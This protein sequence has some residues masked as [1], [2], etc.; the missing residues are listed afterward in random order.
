M[1]INRVLKLSDLSPAL[2]IEL[3]EATVV[4]ANN[5]A[6][7]FYTTNDQ[8]HWELS[9]DFP[10]V[11]PPWPNIWLE[12][13]EPKFINS[14]VHGFYQNPNYHLLSQTG[15]Y[16]KFQQ[17]DNNPSI[18]NIMPKQSI[19]EQ[20]ILLLGNHLMEDYKK[21]GIEITQDIAVKLNEYLNEAKKHIGPDDIEFFNRN[22]K[23]KLQ[24]SI[25]SMGDN[26]AKWI[27]SA[28]LFVESRHGEI[29]YGRVLVQGFIDKNGKFMGSS[30]LEHNKGITV[31]CN[32]NLPPNER[33]A[34]SKNA[35]V[36][37]HVPF[38]TL[39]FIHCKNVKLQEHNLS[40]K[41]SEKFQ[42][43]RKKKTPVYKYY[44]L[45]IDP[46]KSVLKSEGGS[47]QTGLRRALH[48]CRGHFA[49]YTGEAPLFGKVTG[50]FWKSM[51]L[52][53]DA[54][55]GKIDKDYRVKLTS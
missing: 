30:H 29:S 27:M 47:E 34:I 21:R 45:D 16:I 46:M 7:Y 24:E 55:I 1:F 41:L 36:L 51:H 48:I 13:S 50:T 20:M 12:W 18:D 54:S 37:L 14:N 32:P 3:R 19:K 6:E 52:R 11:A 10:N 40:Q 49:T 23:G 25:N 43:N 17:I 9:E 5:V 2:A 35:G 53:G 15:V 28:T 33:E 8:E 22:I 39:S 44:T 31:M 26:G 4:R 42:Q 38:M